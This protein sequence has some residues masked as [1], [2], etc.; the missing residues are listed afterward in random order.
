ML[1][2]AEVYIKNCTMQTENSLVINIMMVLALVYTLYVGYKG[3]RVIFSDKE[4]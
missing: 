2:T 3:F 4:K 1:K